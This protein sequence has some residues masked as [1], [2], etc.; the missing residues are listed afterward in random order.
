MRELDSHR[1]TNGAEKINADQGNQSKMPGLLLLAIERSEV[2]HGDRLC[3]ISVQ[4]W[5]QSLHNKK[6]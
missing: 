6:G 2:M 5:T 1:R 3:A 4:T